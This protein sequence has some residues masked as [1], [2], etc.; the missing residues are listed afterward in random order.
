M[1]NH[2]TGTTGKAPLPF[3]P[4]ELLKLWLLRVVCNDQTSAPQLSCWLVLL[5]LTPSGRTWGC[6]KETGHQEGG[7]WYKPSLR[8]ME[9]L[10]SNA[11]P[12]GQVLLT[13]PIPSY[14]VY[15]PSTNVQGH[16]FWREADL[17]SNHAWACKHSQSHH[18]LNLSLKMLML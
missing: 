15:L 18:L 3:R 12:S 11:Y 8:Q 17:G 13:S 6:G 10:G 9:L 16:G 14:P 2:H 7:K 5:H 1:L 4:W